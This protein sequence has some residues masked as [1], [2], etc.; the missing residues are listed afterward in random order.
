MLG[1]MC[2][3]KGPQHSEAG[4]ARPRNLLVSSQAFYHCATTSYLDMESK[5]ETE[6]KL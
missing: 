6:A 3:A 2:L 4:E 1:K 5:K